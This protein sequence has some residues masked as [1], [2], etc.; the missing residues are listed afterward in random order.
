MT[1]LRD[2][3]GGD[4]ESVLALLRACDLPTDGVP[5]SLDALVVAEEDSRVVGSAGLELHEGH[6]LLRSV[7]VSPELRGRRLA[8]RLCDEAEL[9]AAKLGAKRVYLL[10]ETAERFFARRGYARIERALAPAGIAGSREFAAVCPASA[11]LMEREL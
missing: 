8:S 6:A 2:A 9:R 4:E 5:E 3:R 10:T 7:A 1:L 11:V